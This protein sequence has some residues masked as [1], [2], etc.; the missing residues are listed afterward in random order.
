MVA[1]WAAARPDAELRR[2]ACESAL[3]LLA[4][5]TRFNRDAVR[6]LPTGV[7]LDS[8]QVLLGDIGAGDRHRFRAVGDI[9]NTASRIQGLNRKLGTRALASAS[10]LAGLAGPETRYLGEFLLVGKRSSVELYELLDGEAS[11]ELGQAALDAFAAGM[12][13]FAERDWERG[14][15]L[16]ERVLAARPADGPSRFYVEQCRLHAGRELPRDWRGT[17]RMTAK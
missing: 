13:S 2:N 11:R 9:V 7:G 10:T 15:A 5:V 14:R 17:I 1:I 12:R 4:D 16:F 3:G 8:G 6:A